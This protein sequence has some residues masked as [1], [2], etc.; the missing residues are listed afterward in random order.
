VV[1]AVASRKAVSRLVQSN[2]TIEP[3]SET[4]LLE[5]MKRRNGN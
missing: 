1:A 2:S 3:P 5:L 4:V